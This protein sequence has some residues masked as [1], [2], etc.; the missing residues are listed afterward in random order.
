VTRIGYLTAPAGS[1]PVDE[2]REALRE[3]GYVEG[4]DIVIEYCRRFPRRQSMAT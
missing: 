4:Q 3:L 1:A 2:T